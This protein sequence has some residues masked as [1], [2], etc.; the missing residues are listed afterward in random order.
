MVGDFRALVTTS[1]FRTQQSS[2]AQMVGPAAAAGQLQQLD[3]DAGFALCVEPQ[4]A[5]EGT[6]RF[7]LLRSEMVA[8]PSSAPAPAQYQFEFEVE[9]CAGAVEEGSGG[10]LRCLGGPFGGDIP[11]QTR[12][13]V[14][15]CMLLP[16]G[17]AYSLN[18][19]I[20]AERW[21]AVGPLLQA[22]VSTFRVAAA[23]TPT[24]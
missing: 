21:A 17:A 20:P 18:A 4:R 3:E 19:S 16:D 6:M 10:R 5:A 14:G 11:S 9:S 1:V 22:V 15:R 23:A 12:H 2:V 7:R 24:V 8:P 13:H